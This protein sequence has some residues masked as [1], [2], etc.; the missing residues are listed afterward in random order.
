MTKEKKKINVQFGL[1][2]QEL[3]INAGYSQ[4]DF[5]NECN[6]SEAY[7]GRIERGEFS[8]TIFLVNKIATC[9]GITLSELLEGV[10]KK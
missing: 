2:L 3:R 7:Y 5:A 6:I 10:E 1:K 8:P 4:Y 9:L